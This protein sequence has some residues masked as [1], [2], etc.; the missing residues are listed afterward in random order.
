LGGEEFVVAMPGLDATHAARMAERARPTI[1]NN[2]FLLGEV[3]GAER[4]R[5]ASPISRR[6]VPEIN[7]AAP[8]A[9]FTSLEVCGP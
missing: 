1:E 2:E 7:I 6:V 9:R 8:T 3:G 5:L 4:F